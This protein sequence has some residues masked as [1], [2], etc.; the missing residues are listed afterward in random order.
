MILRLKFEL[1]D[2]ELILKEGVRKAL[3]I[4]LFIF[5]GIKK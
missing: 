4:L 1:M 2:D 5:I 3:F